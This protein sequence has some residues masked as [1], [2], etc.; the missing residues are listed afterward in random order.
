MALALTP[1]LRRCALLPSHLALSKQADRLSQN[2]PD[3]P[4]WDN[5]KQVTVTGSGDGPS[6]VRAPSPRA[7]PAPDLTLPRAGPG[8]RRCDRWFS[9]GLRLAFF[10]GPGCDGRDGRRL[11]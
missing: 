9:E 10:G 6:D 2:A 5:Q 4:D 11:G 1:A 8:I 3:C 7:V